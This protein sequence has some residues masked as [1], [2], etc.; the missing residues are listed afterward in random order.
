MNFEPYFLKWKVFL[1]VNKQEKAFKIL[2]KIEETFDYKIVSLTYEKYWKDK[3][4]YE[5]SFRTYLN[6]KNIENAVFQSLLLSQKLGSD[7][8]IIGPIEIQSNLKEFAINQLF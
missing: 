4:L 5:A 3:S 8:Q 1:K 6:S 7:W 2:S